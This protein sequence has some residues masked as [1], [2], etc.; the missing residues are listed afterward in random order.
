MALASLKQKRRTAN[1]VS[2]RGYSQN[3]LTASSMGE[4]SAT[5]SLANQVRQKREARSTV[6][7][8]E[9][10]NFSQ[11]WETQAE[12]KRQQWQKDLDAQEKDFMKQLE[13]IKNQ[14]NVSS[15]Y[16]AQEKLKMQQAREKAV[17]EQERLMEEEKQKTI[18]AYNEQQ[19]QKALF[20]KKMDSA[21]LDAQQQQGY[22]TGATIG[23]K[24]STKYLTAGT[25]AA[26][27]A[28][29]Y[30]SLTGG[31]LSG[32]TAA[33][34]QI[35]YSAAKPITGLATT[36]SGAAGG[37]AAGAG[38]SWS[39]VGKGVGGAAV[40]YAA[41]DYLAGAMHS[42]SGGTF[43]ARFAGSVAGGAYAGPIG[44]F[45]GG[46]YALAMRVW[47]GSGQKKATPTYQQMTDFVQKTSDQL[48][49]LP[50]EEQKRLLA[51]P[52][53]TQYK[54]MAEAE[55]MRELRLWDEEN[56]RPRNLYEQ[57]SSFLI[58][59]ER[60]L[61]ERDAFIAKTK[62]RWAMGNNIFLDQW[63]KKEQARRNDRGSKLWT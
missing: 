31:G 61:K 22:Q 49:A 21:K 3:P 25:G 15:E 8:N 60:K 9:L 10:K 38:V 24:A 11:K 17:A 13:D 7:S 53:L 29:T 12:A 20:G 5:V 26:T 35:G 44:A 50:P 45:I 58:N 4:R 42:S 55:I 52:Q 6:A 33:T 43:M 28:A 39:N 32:T 14:Y 36:S 54:K 27:N 46:A 56:I 2:Q 37:T 40:G 41:A 18:N 16:I 34:P 47:G 23:Y 1:L 19:R 51:T 30:G 48:K 62:S 63:L 59:R 57:E